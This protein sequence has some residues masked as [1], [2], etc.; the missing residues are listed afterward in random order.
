MYMLREGKRMKQKTFNINDLHN[1]SL[2]L[3][4]GCAAREQQLGY[5]EVSVCSGEEERRRTLHD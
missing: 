3:V 4:G 1:P 5:V 2:N